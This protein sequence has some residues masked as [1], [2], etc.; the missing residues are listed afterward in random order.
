MGF[1]EGGA[2]HNY[3]SETEYI[4]R[5]LEVIEWGRKTWADVPQG[6]RG[7][8][9]SDT[10]LRGVQKL[11]IEALVKV[12]DPRHAHARFNQCFFTYPS[13]LVSRRKTTR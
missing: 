13:R 5:G 4:T 8:V 9:F 12:P 10:F 11:R 3:V 1:L 6:D 7:V 2:R